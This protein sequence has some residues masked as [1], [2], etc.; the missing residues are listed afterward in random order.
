MSERDVLEKAF[1]NALSFLESEETQPDADIDYLIEKIGSNKSIVSA[2]VTSLLK[3]VID[4][5]QDVRLHRTDFAGGYSARV[6]DTHVTSPFFKE[7]FPKYANKESSFL[8]LATRERIKWTQDEGR[9][10]KIRDEKLRRSF[11]DVLAQVEASDVNPVACLTYIFAKLIKLSQQDEQLFHLAEKESLEVSALNIHTVLEMLREHFALRLSSRLPVIAV[12]S[13]YEILL[14]QSAR[15]KDKHLLPLQAHTSSDKHG[16]GDI[17]IYGSD[18][19]PFEIVEVK[20]NIPIDK[21]LIFDIAKKTQDTHI[22]R[23]YILTTFGD[24]FSSREEEAAVSEY[25]LAIKRTQG[26]DIIANGILTTLKYYLRF[27]DDYRQFIESYTKNL[28]NDAK[29]S[30]EVKSSHLEKWNETLRKYRID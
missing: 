10:L 15:Y 12:Y 30:T 4:P 13:I 29:Q 2:L 26:L 8:T 11:L 9:N 16:F 28:I 1:Q 22:N 23:Y 24:G 3:K 14:P 17:E 7:H 25:I 6:L 20:H 27:V 5:Q 21:Y 18:N 19:Q